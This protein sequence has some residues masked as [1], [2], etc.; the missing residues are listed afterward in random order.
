MTHLK[1]NKPDELED[2]LANLRLNEIHY[3][4][5]ICEG[6]IIELDTEDETLITFAR[7]NNPEL[8]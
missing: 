5:A 2:I 8:S 1:S 4:I 7:A 3:K 6:L